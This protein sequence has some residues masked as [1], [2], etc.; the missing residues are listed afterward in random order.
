MGHIGIILI[1]GLALVYGYLNGLHGSASIVATM[2]SSRAL[3]PRQALALAAIGVS[4]GPFLLGIAVANTIGGQ[5]IGSQAT[6]TQVVMAALFGAI[7]WSLITLG[8]KIPSSI[9]QSLIGGLI[10]SVWAGFGVQAILLPG[11]QKTLIA[12]FLS[13][14]LGILVGFGVVRLSYWLCTLATPRI[15]RWLNWGQVLVSM[16]VAVSFGANDGQKMMGI[17]AL[18][19]L[20]SGQVKQFIVPEWV[21]V[22]SA[23]AIGLGTLV[24]G[25]RLIRTLGGKFYKIRPIHGF[26]AQLASGTIIFSAALMG[27]PVSGSQVVTSAILGAGSAERVRMVRWGMAG[28]IMLGWLLTL[29]F[30]ALVSAVF[31]LIL[32]RWVS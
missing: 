21:V 14:L 23:A 4:A 27:M 25:D 32:Q 28:Q 29:P 30:S 17:V 2:I 8:L 9:S 5:L 6:T 13:P 20:T 26:S 1:L 10:G 16:L 12:L 22:L 11:L 18:G 3:G 7:T 31:Y 15:N 19:L 24:G